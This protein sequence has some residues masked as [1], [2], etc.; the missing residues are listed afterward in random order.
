[1]FYDPVAVASSGLPV[2]V[3]ISAGEGTACRFDA[4]IATRIRF[5]TS[6]T[7]E[8]TATQGG[9]SQ[10]NSAATVQVIVVNALNQTITFGAIADMKFG[11]PKFQLTATASS[12]LPVS[13]RVGTTFADPGCSVTTTGRVTLE[14]AGRCEIIASQPGNTSYLPAPEVTQL[15]TVSPD[16]AGAPHLMSVSVSNSAI[17]AKFRAPSYLGGSAI[18]AYRLE[19]TNGDG[20]RYVNPGC[21]PSATDVVCE[22]VGMPLGVAYTVRIAAVTAAGIGTFSEP[23]LPVTPGAT[24]IAVSMLSAQQTAGQ[25]EV[26]WTP[27]ASFDS[28]FEAYEIYVWPLNAD[29]PEEPNFVMTGDSQASSANFTLIEPSSTTDIGTQQLQFFSLQSQSAEVTRAS[30]Y[31]IRV[32]TLTDESPDAF[33]D[34]NVASGMQLGMGVP[35]RPRNEQ[36]TVMADSL[37]AAWSP[38]VFDGGEAITHYIV[39]INDLE[40]RIENETGLL[41]IEHGELR[42]GQTYEISIYAYNSVGASEPAILTHSIPAP[43]APPAPVLPP[44]EDE[45]ELEPAP[46]PESVKPGPESP[47]S[48]A[49][50]P[51]P[52]PSPGDLLGGDEGTDAEE[53]SGSL[54]PERPSRPTQPDGDGSDSGSGG[55]GSTAEAD[56]ASAGELQAGTLQLLLLVLLL[57]ALLLLARRLKQRKASAQEHR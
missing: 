1:M 57:I 47:S 15:F 19:A 16:K 20:D 13:Y 35:A 24:E 25:L 45:E 42:A 54:G 41:F 29:R 14:R 37:L 31:N 43:P 4:E 55:D 40:T 7:C 56:G 46:A 49:N 51:R 33:D 32:V 39:K 38:P 36:L 6:G 8:L 11:D 17:V 27:P 18:S 34:I 9:S 48:G 53:G 22:L 44:V 21:Q 52:T 30:S 26:T 2:V 3:T 23:S 50:N 5:M 12:G 10:F 28:E